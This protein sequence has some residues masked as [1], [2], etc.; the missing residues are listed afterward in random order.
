MKEPKFIAP[1]QQYTYEEFLEGS[2]RK[3]IDEK[4]NI[5]KIPDITKA[6][7]NDKKILNK[8]KN[9]HKQCKNVDPSKRPTATEVLIRYLQ[10][11]H[12]VS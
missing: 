7:V 5:W 2:S 9:I 1:E 4:T 3:P 11:L 10:V 6:L 8:L 12:S